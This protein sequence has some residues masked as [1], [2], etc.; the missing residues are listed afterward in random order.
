VLVSV[1]NNAMILR[2]PFGIFG[3]V[4]EF[5]VALPVLS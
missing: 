5:H 2:R 3:R 4:K 1:G